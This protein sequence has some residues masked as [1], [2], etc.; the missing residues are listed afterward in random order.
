MDRFHALNNHPAVLTW[1]CTVAAVTWP[2]GWHFKFENDK[3]TSRLPWAWLRWYYCMYISLN[4]KYVEITVFF[5]HTEVTL[6]DMCCVERVHSTSLKVLNSNVKFS[7][8]FY[9]L[10]NVFLVHVTSKWTEI[11][12]ITFRQ[13]YEWFVMWQRTSDTVILKWSVHIQIKVHPDLWFHYYKCQKENI[14]IMPK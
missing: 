2:C 14:I 4:S 10:W 6:H 8:I 5:N 13:E 12:N 9:I 7:F 3:E 11:N 1:W